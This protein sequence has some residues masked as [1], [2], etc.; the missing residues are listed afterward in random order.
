M[1]RLSNAVQKA[2]NILGRTSIPFWSPRYEA[3]MIVPSNM[4]GSA[5]RG[6]VY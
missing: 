2:E 3:H 6:G 1:K 4:T 5:I